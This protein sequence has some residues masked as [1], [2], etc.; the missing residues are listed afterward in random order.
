MRG[1]PSISYYIKLQ[2]FATQRKRLIKKNIILDQFFLMTNTQKSKYTMVAMKLVSSTFSINLNFEPLVIL[3]MN[4][5]GSQKNNSNCSGK[6][7]SCY[8]KWRDN[9][10]CFWFNQ[11]ASDM[12]RGQHEIPRLTQWPSPNATSSHCCATQISFNWPTKNQTVTTIS[13]GLLRC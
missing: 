2:Y 7:E 4:P 1:N 10:Y 5:S 12:L 9:F 13:L 3:W 11:Q 8:P 6:C